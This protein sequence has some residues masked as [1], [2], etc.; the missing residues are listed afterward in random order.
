MMN[1]T[2]ITCIVS[3]LFTVGLLPSIAQARP[4]VRT[5]SSAT[6]DVDGVTGPRLTVREYTADHTGAGSYSSDQYIEVTITPTLHSDWPLEVTT[7][8][9]LTPAPDQGF[10]DY[11]VSYFDE[12]TKNDLIGPGSSVVWSPGYIYQGQYQHLVERFA[13]MMREDFP[14][15]CFHS[16]YILQSGSF[17]G[18]DSDDNDGLSI[19]EGEHYFGFR[20]VGDDLQTRYGW[21][22]F[23][24]TRVPAS[25]VNGAGCDFS[26]PSTFPDAGQVQILQIGWET[27]PD[28]P[29]AVGVE[30][31]PADLNFD[32][33]VD[34][35][36]V[37]TFITAFS[38]QEHI[39]D[40]DGNGDWDFFDVSSFISMYQDSCDL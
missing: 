6:L 24:F 36:D 23:R 5:G 10:E 33:D 31:C 17:P 13:Y 38:A 18:F 25:Q 12:M 4:E 16:P 29:I 14:W 7:G 1:M 30:Y 19:I 27:E 9:E 26:D 15:S 39:A 37:S 20:W 35:F 2:A 3:S 8:P 11:R 28:T 40:I 21:V 22:K 32:A 34:F